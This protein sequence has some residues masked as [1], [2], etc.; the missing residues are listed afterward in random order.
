MTEGRSR[1]GNLINTRLVIAGKEMDCFWSADRQRARGVRIS[2]VIIP[3]TEK[4][5]AG[6]NGGDGCCCCRVMRSRV[7]RVY[8][9]CCISRISRS[10]RIFARVLQEN[11]A[12][13]TSMFL[14]A[15][16][17]N[18]AAVLSSAHCCRPAIAGRAL[19][20]SP[21]SNECSLFSRQSLPWI[22]SRECVSRDTGASPK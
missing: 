14:Y 16:A 15:P 9:T 2:H 18:F 1:R 11:A 17:V 21:S 13:R 3:M 7:P 6:R 10:I 8:F 12:F 22:F 19:Q 5:P 4:A 20:M